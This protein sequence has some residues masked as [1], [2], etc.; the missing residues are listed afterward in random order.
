MNVN[1]T[2]IVG[3]LALV[4]GVGLCLIA[5]VRAAA[6]VVLLGCIALLLLCAG[7]LF[8]F[9][10]YIQVREDRDAA[11]KDERAEARRG[12]MTASE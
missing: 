6:G 5:P 12:M 4:I 2:L 7:V 10:G 9:M 3:A 8:I 11:T 1:Q